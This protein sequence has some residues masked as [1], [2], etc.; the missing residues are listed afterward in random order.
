MTATKIDG[1]T[2]ARQERSLKKRRAVEQAVATLK[3]RNEAITFKAVAILANVSRQ[4][5]YNNFKEAIAAE[6]NNTRAQS[7]EVDGVSVP[8]RTPE[9]Y[10]HIEAVL[11]N[12]VDR[13]KK[14]LGSVRMENARLK[15]E[16]E[17]ERGRAE[18]FRQNWINAKK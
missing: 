12:K 7:T 5:L 8:A 4:Y 3:D 16:L 17:K 11:R 2:Q 13:L 18:H 1:L 15:Q 6:R 10:R 9:E 14:D